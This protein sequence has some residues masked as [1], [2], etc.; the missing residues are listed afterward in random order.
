MGV[1]LTKT[2]LLGTAKTAKTDGEGFL[3]IRIDKDKSYSKDLKS[4]RK[5][6][7]EKYS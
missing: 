1:V 6:R 5:I 7:E 4:I 2:L 3:N